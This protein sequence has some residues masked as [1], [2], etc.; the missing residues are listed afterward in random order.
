[1]SHVA[2]HCK[3]CPYSEFF[4]SVFSLIW[5]DG[6]IRSI[7]PYSIRMRGK[8]GPEKSLKRTLSMQCM[9]ILTNTFLVFYILL[10]RSPKGWWIKLQNWRIWENISHIALGNHCVKSTRIVLVR[11]R[12]NAGRNNSG[13]RHFLR[14]DRA[15][16]SSDI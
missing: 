2:S 11:M 15:I 13:Y 12:E 6:K 16:T 8:Y 1:M 14:S 10:F 7:S 3:K 5:T 9:A 4:W